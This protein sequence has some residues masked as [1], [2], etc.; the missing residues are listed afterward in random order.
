MNP[1]PSTSTQ[2]TDE[3]REK[4]DALKLHGIKAPD[5]PGL[6]PYV[7]PVMERAE[8]FWQGRMDAKHVLHEC[9]MSRMQLWIVADSVDDIDAVIVTQVAHYPNRLVSRYVMVSGNRM[10]TWADTDDVLTEWAK[11]Q[12][13]S[14]M[15]ATGR[16]GWKAKMKA[17]GWS[18]PT[19]VYEKE[20]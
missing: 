8:G 18:S 3:T 15:E 2:P 7:L 14:M 10:E 6:W 5:I 4:M 13:C 11:A 19:A 1:S 12:G 17:R 9:M 20:I 16:H